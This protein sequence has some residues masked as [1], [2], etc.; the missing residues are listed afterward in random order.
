MFHNVGIKIVSLGSLSFILVA[1]TLVH[2]VYVQILVATM[3]SQD[4]YIILGMFFFYKITICY[5]I[6]IDSIVNI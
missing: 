3:C 1:F 2:L 6:Y 5:N 4:C